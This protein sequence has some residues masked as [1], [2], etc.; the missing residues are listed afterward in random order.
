MNALAKLALRA[1]QY[2]SSTS[3]KRAGRSLS[4]WLMALESIEVSS[5]PDVD[6]S[7]DLQK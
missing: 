7:K 3:L 5:T 6:T 1:E 4:K 2:S